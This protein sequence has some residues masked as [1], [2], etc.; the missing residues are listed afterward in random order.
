M[1][2]VQ[3]C[4]VGATLAP[5]VVYFQS[6]E[7]LSGMPNTSLKTTALYL[8]HFFSVEC[9]THKPIEPYI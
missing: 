1:V 9:E 3:T 7:F 6:I 5:L 8:K 4:E 2:A